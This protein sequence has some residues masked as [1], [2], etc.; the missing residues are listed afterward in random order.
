MAILCD[1]R[2]AGAFTQV[3]QSRYGGVQR[4]VL[5]RRETALGRVGGDN[6][7]E[8]AVDHQDARLETRADS[9]RIESSD[10]M[11]DIARRTGPDAH[12]WSDEPDIKGTRSSGWIAV[13]LPPAEC[14][15][16]V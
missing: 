14:A 7:P 1:C 15:G 10:D 3:E 13:Y 2:S 5:G 6:G 4:G 8:S 12:Y 11:Y 9:I 16:P